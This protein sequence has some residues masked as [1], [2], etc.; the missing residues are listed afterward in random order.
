MWYLEALDKGLENLV[1]LLE[2]ICLIIQIYYLLK[3]NK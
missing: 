1:R 2:I 3:N